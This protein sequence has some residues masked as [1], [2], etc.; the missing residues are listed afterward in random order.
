MYNH[1]YQLTHDMDCF[2]VLNG[3][4]THIA[5]NGGIVP[6][7]LGTVEELRAMQTQVANI[8]GTLMYGLNTDYLGTLQADD[9]PSRQVLEDVG[10]ELNV[11]KDMFGNDEYSDIPFHWKVYSHSFVEMARKGFWSFDRVGVMPNGMDV[12]MLIAWPTYSEKKTLLPRIGHQ[13][14][15]RDYN[16]W[17]QCENCSCLPLAEMIN[18]AEKKDK[19]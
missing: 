7:K 14:E 3:Y 1:V 17:C 10:K 15:L 16:L 4:A 18:K 5:T 8:E 11:I 2:F 12:Y 13:F 19:L 6:A 9:F